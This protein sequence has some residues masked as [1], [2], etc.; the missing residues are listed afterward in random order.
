MCDA[1]QWYL[2]WMSACAVAGADHGSLAERVLAAVRSACARRGLGWGIGASCFTTLS[3]LVIPTARH[4]GLFQPRALV[5]NPFGIHDCALMRN[6]VGIHDCA[7][8]R[9]PVGIPLRSN[10][11][12]VGAPSGKPVSRVDDEASAVLRDG[13]EDGDFLPIRGF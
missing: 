11:Q 1:M 4:P 5:R 8:M 3:G 13:V 6:P 7:L 12:A 10:T 9:E 2:K